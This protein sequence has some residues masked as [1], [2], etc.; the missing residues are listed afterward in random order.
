MINSTAS[1]E[2]ASKS[3]FKLA[4]KVTASSSQLKDQQLFLLL[5]QI[6]RYIPPRVYYGH[7]ITKSK[8][9]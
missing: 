1:N 2:S 9:L 5:F 7:I 8:H 6:P 3:S 4:S